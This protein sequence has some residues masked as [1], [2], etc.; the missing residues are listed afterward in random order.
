MLRARRARSRSPRRQLPPPPP[1]PPQWRIEQLQREADD[2]DH[3]D[4]PADVD[5]PPS[6]IEQVQEI[7]AIEFCSESSWI[8]DPTLRVSRS[9]AL[10]HVLSHCFHALLTYTLDDGGDEGAGGLSQGAIHRDARYVR[11]LRIHHLLHLLPPR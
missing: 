9:L 6:D 2:T 3:P 4:D 8:C 5:T 1:P 7:M 10:P 11:D